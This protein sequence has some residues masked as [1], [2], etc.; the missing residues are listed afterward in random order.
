M[1]LVEERRAIQD[2][3]NLKRNRRLIEG[4]QSQQE[5]IDAEKAKADAFRKQL[6]DPEFKAISERYDTI[7][8]ELDQLKKE[9]DE[10]Y[11]SR[12]DLFDQRSTLQAELDVLWDKKKASAKE[13]REAQDIYWAKVKEDRERKAEKARSAR[14]AAED[15]KKKELIDRLRE[16]GSVPAYQSQIEDCQTLID[17]LSG[18]ASS[19]SAGLSL[20]REVVAGVPDLDIRKVDDGVDKNLVPVKKKGDDDN[21]FVASTFSI[22]RILVLALD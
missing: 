11:S 12:N 17:Q 8:T 7:K 9:G 10:A 3:Q 6:D 20:N 1:K 15:E 21:Y 2:I 19:S 18:T 16:E 4:F 22:A 5:A 13:Y 14:R